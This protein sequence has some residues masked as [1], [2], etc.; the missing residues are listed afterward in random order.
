MDV[1]LVR[2]ADTLLVKIK[3]IKFKSY[4]KFAASVN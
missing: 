4:P 3:K 1:M 2:V